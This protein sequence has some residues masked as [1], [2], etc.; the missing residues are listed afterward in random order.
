MGFSAQR[1]IIG[2]RGAS[3]LAPENTL[4]AFRLAA[5]L[6]V[7]A[8][9]LD[10]HR[11]EGNLVVLHDDR[12]DRTTSGGGALATYSLAA[13]RR[14]D[15][16]ERQQVPLLEEVFRV[17]PAQVGINIELKGRNTAQLAA[18]LAAREQAERGRE[19]LI[20][21]FHREELRRAAALYGREL[22]L[23]PLFRRW[24][25]DGWRFA[26]ELGAWSVHLSL[27]I[28]RQTRLM[29]ARRR[30]LRVLVYTVNQKREADRMFRWGA[31]GIFT[32]Y[33]DRLATPPRREA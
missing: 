16:G 25:R 27:R 22:K 17:L 29:E 32:D 6:G 24:P 9:E 13:L 31:T 2:H 3:G 33:P 20:S 14:L 28:A 1:L 23:A 10:V 26:A 7:D 18:A 30:G 11:L 5:E 15:A 4:A 21:S 19:V 8:V 12:L